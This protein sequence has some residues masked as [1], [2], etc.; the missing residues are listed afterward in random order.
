MQVC[1]RWWE[2]FVIFDWKVTIIMTLK[3]DD[4][5]KTNSY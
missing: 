4:G 2:I 5:K 1:N 3:Q